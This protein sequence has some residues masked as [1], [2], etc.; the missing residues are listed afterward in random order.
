MTGLTFIREMM[1]S[2]IDILLHTKYK[3]C[4]HSKEEMKGAR[5]CGSQ[6]EPYKPVGSNKQDIPL[7][8]EEMDCKT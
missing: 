2:V 8:W 1:S 6:L 7:Y 5:V 4:T 3:G